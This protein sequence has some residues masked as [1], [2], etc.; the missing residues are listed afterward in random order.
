MSAFLSG[1][2]TVT[3]GP[4]NHE[5]VA[6]RPLVPRSTG[7]VQSDPTGANSSQPRPPH[8]FGHN[9]GTTMSGNWKAS[10]LSEAYSSLGMT[11]SDASD[12][13]W[14]IIL[15]SENESD[16]YYAF[17][18]LAYSEPVD[19]SNTK[20]AMQILRVTR[21]EDT[22]RRLVVL[23]G[24]HLRSSRDS[25][26][27]LL[28]DEIASRFSWSV[29]IK[30]NVQSSRDSICSRY[31]NDS[32]RKSIEQLRSFGMPLEEVKENI[33]AFYSLSTDDIDAYFGLRE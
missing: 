12:P 14:D 23:L 32:V 13:L 8:Y 30:N 24:V 27:L 6:A 26:S 3:D 9:Q 31:M 2:W 33:K 7:R 1:G 28:L 15:N 4:Q 21:N 20:K 16:R 5:R 18:I 10:L 11:A 17:S 25:E 29:D 19:A 22:A